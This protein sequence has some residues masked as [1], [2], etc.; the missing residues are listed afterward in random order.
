MWELKGLLTVT[1]CLSWDV[2]HSGT[3]NIETEG[4][5]S[6]HGSQNSHFGET[7]TQIQTGTETWTV[8]SAPLE[9]NQT[10]TRTGR[11]YKCSYSRGQCQPL[12]VNAPPEAGAISL[13]LSLSALN[14]GE[15]A[16]L[17]PQHQGIVPQV[18]LAALL[19]HQVTFN[20]EFDVSDSGSEDLAANFTVTATSGNAVRITNEST[21]TRTLFLR[22]TVSVVTSGI[23][24]TRHINVTAGSQEQRL[25]KH[26]YQV[27]NLG[28]RSVPIGVILSVPDRLSGQSIWNVSV[29]PRNQTHR[30]VCSPSIDRGKRP[31]GISVHN[32][33]D[34]VTEDCGIAPC[35]LLRCEVSNLRGHEKVIFDI[36][37][38]VRTEA[39]TQLNV[40]QFQ[41]ISK[42]RLRY[43]QQKYVDVSNVNDKLK[44]SMIETEVDVLVMA[45]HLVEIVAGSV[46]GLFLLMICCVVLYKLGFFKR[47]KASGDKDPLQKDSPPATEGSAAE[48]ATAQS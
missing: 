22:Y 21:L 18:Y 43:D 4:A 7:V 24:S 1:L 36:Q 9:V 6:F 31:Q 34:N 14:V 38:E 20:A 13:G 47:N 19:V 44:E 23:E 11:L 41:L 3:F 40:K 33:Q 32:R 28:D 10:G 37:G 16:F 30:S 15:G 26:S 25:V 29:S 8:V 39:I 48:A 45:D 17:I 2:P 46:A 27:E 35:I 12:A 42:L 5:Q